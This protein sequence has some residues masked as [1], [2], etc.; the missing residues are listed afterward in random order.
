MKTSQ[1][2]DFYRF[3]CWSQKQ[4]KIKQNYRKEENTDTSRGQGLVSSEMIP[5]NVLYRSI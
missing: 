2:Q 1:E 5:G 3:T 4:Q